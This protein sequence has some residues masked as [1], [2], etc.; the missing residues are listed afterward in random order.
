VGLAGWSA[1]RWEARRAFRSAMDGFDVRD[2]LG[3][4]AIPTIVLHVTRDCY[5][6]VHT[7][8]SLSD[9]L[10]SGELRLIPEAGHVLPLTHGGAVVEAVSDLLTAARQAPAAPSSA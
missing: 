1:T 8:R 2:R 7:A 5:F 4:I 10:P 6:T 3:G 9:G